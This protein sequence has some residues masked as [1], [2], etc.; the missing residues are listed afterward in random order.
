[1]LG[2]LCVAA[3]AQLTDITQTPN[4]E[5]L[6]IQRSLTDQI[7]AGRGSANTPGSSLFIIQRDPFRSIVRGRQLF[8]RKF[9]RA[10]GLGPRTQDGIGDISAHPAIG[11]GL[12]DSCA[13][14]HGRPRGS[15]GT[16]G[17]VYTRPYSRDAPHLFGM[18]LVEMIA[19]EITTHLRQ[20]R[21]QG[22]AIATVTGSPVTLQLQDK[23]IS[24]G[25]ITAYPSGQ[26]DTSNVVG[27][28]EDLRVKPF[29]AEGSEFS[30]RAFIVGALDAEMGL[31]SFDPDLATAAAG[32]LVTTPSGL[33]LDGSKDSIT[34]P[35]AA[36]ASAD[37]DGDGVTDEAPESIVDHLEFY[38]LNYFKPGQHRQ[39]VTAQRGQYFFDAIGCTDCHKRDIWIDNDRRVA[40]VET[41]FNPRLG[42]INSLYASAKPL[43]DTQ[44]GGG[45]PSFKLPSGQAFLVRNIYADFRRHD[46]GPA[47]WELNFDGTVTT[48]FMTEPLWGVGTTAPY[49]HD[50]RSIN[51]HEVILRHGGDAQVSRDAYAQ[52]PTERQEMI[53]QFLRSLVLFPP[54][55]TASNLH[56]ADRTHPQFPLRGHGSIDL[57]V[58][59]NVPGIKE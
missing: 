54:A 23:G 39:T 34:A 44:P 50:G 3:P 24:Y 38:L 45:Y 30:M 14:C 28:D 20:T 16:G 9:T 17:N 41:T 46:L 57:S 35:P 59:F 26:V 40:D 49:G 53:R 33:V 19:D 31:E 29:F 13:S 48:E 1:M 51:L 8:Q 42:A 15:A 32:G 18:G 52:L 12:A 6:G 22:L 7:G 25:S 37:P 36:S 21:Q 10:Q 5:N 27:V 55:D 58:L 47:F 56:P 11:A 2:A 4:Q 43:F